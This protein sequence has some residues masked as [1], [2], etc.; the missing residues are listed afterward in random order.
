MNV[1][2]TNRG[3]NHAE[4][5]ELAL[6]GH[7]GSASAPSDAAR[8]ELLLECLGWFEG[9][10][11]LAEMDLDRARLVRDAFQLASGRT[12]L[13][14][15]ELVRSRKEHAEKTSPELLGLLRD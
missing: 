11:N 5:D 13:D 10:P 1:C 2:G 12:R 4:S 14:S 6:G 7:R 8:R 9:S 3:Q 15:H